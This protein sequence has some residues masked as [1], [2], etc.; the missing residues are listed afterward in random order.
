MQRVGQSQSSVSDETKAA[1]RLKVQ[2]ILN[3][4]KNGNTGPEEKKKL[5]MILKVGFCQLFVICRVT[6][7]LV[8]PL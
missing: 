1:A 3:S 5:L 7:G 6:V 4:M 8:L 2:Q